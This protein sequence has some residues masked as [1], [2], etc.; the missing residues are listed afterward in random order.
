MATV[1]ISKFD[2]DVILVDPENAK[3]SN[4]LDVREKVVSFMYVEVRIATRKALTSKNTSC[5]SAAPTSV[6]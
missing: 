3:L 4:F 5:T 1:V 6:S 2:A